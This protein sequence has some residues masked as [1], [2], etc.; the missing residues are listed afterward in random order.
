MNKLTIIF[1][2][3][4]LI[5]ITGCLSIN[6][7]NSLPITRTQININSIPIIIW[8]TCNDLN[9]TYPSLDCDAHYCCHVSQWNGQC[10]N[11]SEHK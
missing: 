6:D 3:L 1:F 8:L 11:L 9:Q 5:C 7:N 4:S 10:C 2:L